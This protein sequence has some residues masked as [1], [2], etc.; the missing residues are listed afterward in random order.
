MRI[1]LGFFRG[2]ANCDGTVNFGDINPF[3]LALSSPGSYGQ[4]YP[5]CNLATAD[6]NGDVQVDFADINPFVAA[7]AGD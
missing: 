7:L 5:Q 2:D 4:Q 3:V 1:A 6:M